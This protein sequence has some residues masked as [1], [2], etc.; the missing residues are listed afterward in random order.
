V[1]CVG[2][3]KVDIHIGGDGFVQRTG[4]VVARLGLGIERIQMRRPAPHPDLDDS[5]GLGGH[6]HSLGTTTGPIAHHETRRPDKAQTH[7][8]TSGDWR[9]QRLHA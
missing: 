3:A 6:L 5:F 2:H 8:F 1:A 7:R 9:I 4:I